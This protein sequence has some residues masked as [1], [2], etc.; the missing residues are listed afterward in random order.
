M[1]DDRRECPVCGEEVT[2]YPAHYRYEC[3][4]AANE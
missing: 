2:Q 3:E 1:T 4:G